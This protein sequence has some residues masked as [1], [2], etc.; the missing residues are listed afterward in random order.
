M[1][2]RAHLHDHLGRF[3][4]LGCRC[5]RRLGPRRSCQRRLSRGGGFG[6]HRLGALLGLKAHIVGHLGA[7]AQKLV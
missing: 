6:F 1:A 2:R 3:R 4:R 5:G 7:H